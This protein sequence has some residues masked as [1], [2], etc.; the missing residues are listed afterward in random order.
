MASSP[1]FASVLQ[2]IID[3]AHVRS[4]PPHSVVLCGSALSVVSGLLSGTKSLRGRAQLDMTLRPFSSGLSAE[5]WG[6]RDPDIAFHVDAVLDGTAGYRS[7]VGG[8]PKTLRGF[9]T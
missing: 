5:S 8:T 2:D 4:Y 9:A 3:E 1:E 6:I 7:L